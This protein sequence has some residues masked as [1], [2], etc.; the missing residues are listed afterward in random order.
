MLTCFNAGSR[1]CGACGEYLAELPQLLTSIP[2]LYSWIIPSLCWSIFLF[3]YFLS[4]TAAKPAGLWLWSGPVNL[5]RTKKGI[6]GP[7]VVFCCAQK[8]CLNLH[9]YSSNCTC[10][11]FS[12]CYFP[13]RSS[14]LSGRTKS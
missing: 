5:T 2:C 6:C 3:F 11:L 14:I 4:S 12:L 9:T 10:L 8:V 13:T 7:P 1:F